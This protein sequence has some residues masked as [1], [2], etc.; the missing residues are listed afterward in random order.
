M[1][2]FSP[3]PV[4]ESVDKTLADYLLRQFWRLNLYLQNYESNMHF[5]GV[6]HAETYNQGDVV[7]DGGSSWVAV[8]PT[9]EKPGGA[10]RHWVK[11]P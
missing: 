5:K 3:D 8:Q 9:G 7:V 10:A 4:P 6:W 1:T 2:E 11:L